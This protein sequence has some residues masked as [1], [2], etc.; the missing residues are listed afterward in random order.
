MFAFEVDFVELKHLFFLYS[1][2]LFN[3]T[4]ETKKKTCTSRYLLDP[5]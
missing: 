3:I 4:S 2:I 1:L 5:G